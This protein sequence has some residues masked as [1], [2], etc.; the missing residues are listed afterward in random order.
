MASGLHLIGKIGTMPPPKREE[1]CSA[2]FLNAWAPSVF[3]AHFAVLIG[4]AAARTLHVLGGTLRR[5]GRSDEYS[6]LAAAW[7]S[8]GHERLAI[9]ATV[10]GI[11]E[12]AV[13]GVAGPFA[14]RAYRPGGLGD[15]AAQV[16]FDPGLGGVWIWRVRGGLRPVR[17]LAAELA[18][19]Q[20]L[21]RRGG[22]GCRH[23][24]WAGET[25]HLQSQPKTVGG[26]G[27]EKRSACP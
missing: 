4:T 1:S 24:A 6:E 23:H 18:A 21:G 7:V 22:G 5:A 15:C 16:E 12:R 14:S 8:G 10:Y 17:H 25:A 11:A 13:A 20:C 9:A 26:A 2:A 3:A 27:G 19:I